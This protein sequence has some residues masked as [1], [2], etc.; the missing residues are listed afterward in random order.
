L[1]SWRCPY[2]GYLN[3]AGESL[4]VKRVLTAR[5]ALVVVQEMKAKEGLKP[6]FKRA[7]MLA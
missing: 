2:C 6:I 3:K 4:I 5:D 7:S 1:S